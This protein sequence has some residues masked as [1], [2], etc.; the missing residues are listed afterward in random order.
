ME[1]P[2]ERGI[3]GAV[4]PNFGLLVWGVC[5]ETTMETKYNGEDVEIDWENS[6]IKILFPNGDFLFTSMLDDDLTFVGNGVREALIE[7]TVE[8]D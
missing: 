4:A 1:A 3:T 7:H 8:D 5:A 6:I 2:T